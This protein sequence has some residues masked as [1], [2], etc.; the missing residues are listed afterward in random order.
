MVPAVDSGSAVFTTGVK[1]VVPMPM[2]EDQL[3]T[4]EWTGYPNLIP[5]PF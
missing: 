2:R 1:H 3:K 5:A 4:R